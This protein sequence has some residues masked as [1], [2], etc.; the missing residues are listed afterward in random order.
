VSRCEICDCLIVRLPGLPWRRADA[1][2]EA[3]AWPAPIPEAP[4]PGGAAK[5]DRP[6]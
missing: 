4:G 6:Q 5:A 2:E 1:Q 3:D